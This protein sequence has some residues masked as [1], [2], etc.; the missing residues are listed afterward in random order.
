MTH[1]STQAR[2]RGTVRFMPSVMTLRPARRG[3]ASKAITVQKNPLRSVD[4]CLIA[5]IQEQF[6]VFRINDIVMF[7]LTAVRVGRRTA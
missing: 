6:M 1:G 5:H 2:S 4:R 3:A 7:C